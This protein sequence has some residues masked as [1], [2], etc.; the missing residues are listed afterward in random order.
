[1]AKS[2]HTKEKKGLSSHSVGNENAVTALTYSSS[3]SVHKVM[4]VVLLATAFYAHK[5]FCAVQF[6]NDRFFSML[7]EV[8]RELSLQSEQ[9]HYYSYYKQ[10]VHQLK[11][12]PE[13]S[14][15]TAAANATAD[16]LWD[17]T[18]EYP[19]TINVI[20]RFTIYPEIATAILYE[21]YDTVVHRWL[22]WKTKECYSVFSEVDKTVELQTCNGLGHPIVFYIECVWNMQGLHALALALACYLVGGQSLL[23]G[24]TGVLMLFFNHSESMRA[25]WSPPLRESWAF[26][27]FVVQHCVILF[28]LIEHATPSAEQRKNPAGKHSRSGG[29]GPCLTQRAHGLLLAGVTV[30][31]CVSWQLSQFVLTTQATVFGLLYVMGY[32]SPEN[33][34]V[35]CGAFVASFL[36]TVLALMGNDLLLASAMPPF[37]LATIATS[38]Y[39]GNVLMDTRTP[40]R[41][42]IGAGLCILGGTAVSAAA[43]KGLVYIATLPF[44]PASAIALGGAADS[45]HIFVMLGVK[46]GFI[47]PT[48]DTMLYMC[49]PEF[50]TMQDE[51]FNVSITG[52]LPCALLV[53]LKITVNVVNDVFVVIPMTA[54]SA[55]RQA[56]AAHV[57]VLLSFVWSTAMAVLFMRL[58]VFWLFSLVVLAAQIVGPDFHRGVTAMPLAADLRTVPRATFVV[59]ILAFTVATGIDNVRESLSVMGEAANPDGTAFVSFINTSTSPDAVFAGSMTVMSHVRATTGRAI[60]NHP[61][62]ESEGIRQRTLDVYSL[63]SRRSDRQVWEALRKYG[64]DYAAI[65]T[66]FCLQRWAP[67]E[68]DNFRGCGISE[69][70]TNIVDADV[71]NYRDGDVFC[72]PWCVCR[73]CTCLCAVRAV[74]AM[75]V[76]RCACVV[77][78]CCVCWHQRSCAADHRCG[79]NDGA[80]QDRQQA[81]PQRL[82]RGRVPQHPVPRAQAAAPRRR[83][84]RVMPNPRTQ[85]DPDV[86]GPDIATPVG[87]VCPPSGCARG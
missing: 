11:A 14:F 32:V 54:T 40:L 86:E 26:P 65:E 80:L 58:K 71:P 13:S 23:C 25:Q 63:V 46:M 20:E 43:I 16:L 7:T 8:E 1:M 35:L 68:D 66:P 39:Y 6:E 34:R 61:H 67:G 78:A 83:R 19:D 72:E 81:A 73:V 17:T 38:Q 56:H 52:L 51:Y 4:L 74:R 28:Y 21:T 59:A 18:T 87:G 75:C 70:F 77:R 15:F 37:A 29:A 55:S 3:S 84:P 5:S 49:A 76:V 79:I 41:T 22:G 36:V 50:Q 12:R 24:A 30:W 69:V 60:V 57:F 44:R 82:L 9:A 64:T 47:A 48:F 2:A 62:Y 33:V 42:R 31:F 85:R 27:V 10:F 45:G 53:A